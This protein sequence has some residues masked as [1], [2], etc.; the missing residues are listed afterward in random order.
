MWPLLHTGTFYKNKIKL[1][2]RKKVSMSQ[3]PPSSQTD[4][5]SP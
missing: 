4:V 1:K 3:V 2:K 5:S